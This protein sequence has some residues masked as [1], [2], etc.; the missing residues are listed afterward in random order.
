M[1]RL[2]S[3]VEVIVRKQRLVEGLVRQGDMWPWPDAKEPPVH[4]VLTLDV[5][6]VFGS[7]VVTHDDA[8]RVAGLFKSE[9]QLP[10]LYASMGCLIPRALDHRLDGVKLRGGAQAG[11]SAAGVVLTVGKW[12]IPAEEARDLVLC[13]RALPIGVLEFCLILLRQISRVFA[14]PVAVGSVVLGPTI[15]AAESGVELCVRVGGMILWEAAD[16]S[17]DYFAAAKEV[18]LPINRKTRSF[19][20]D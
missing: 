7:G 8:V 18:L 1:T 16:G 3:E 17:R 11:A 20:K 9:R 6:Q 10:G 12:R 13:D 15:L 19:V 14:L 4:F 5:G 2:L